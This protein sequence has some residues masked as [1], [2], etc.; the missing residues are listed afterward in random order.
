MTSDVLALPAPTRLIAVPGFARLFVSG[1]LSHMT[2]WG[3]LFLG[4]LVVTQLTDSPV[5]NQLVG[6]C[7]F[8]PMLLGGL[9]AGA[10]SD[11]VDRRRL[12]LA[13][14]A[15]SIPVAVAMA[16]VAQLGLVQV[17]MVLVFTLAIGFG[18]VVNMTGLRP[19]M[20]EVAGPTFAARALALDSAGV[21]SASMAGA[22]A[23][24]AL[25]DAVGTGAAFG[26]LAL[27]LCA[28][29]TL[30]R[31]VPSTVVPPVPAAAA[32]PGP[33]FDEQLQASLGLLRRSPRLASVLGVT[34][35]MNLFHFSFLPL[36]PVMA[37]Q[38]AAS[39]LLAGV[40]GSAAG[41]GQL[42]GGMVLATR[43]STSHGHAYVGGSAIAL[44]GLCL[45]ATAPVLGLACAALL[46]A[47]MGQA[48]FA[49]MQSLLAIE[50]ATAAERGA[51]LGLL[52][53]AIGALPLGMVGIGVVAEL[54]G[55]RATMLAS[56]L[57]GLALLAL[58]VRRLPHLLMRV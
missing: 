51:A 31:S 7:V 50:S 56:S 18:G 15:A 20:Y 42:V 19:L 13:T 35:V 52:S 54:L 14:Q 47:G 1:W 33:R 26:L 30:L 55:P 12:V 3:G 40:L 23:G 36:V 21:A 46:L 41:C 37:E 27:L 11:R 29:T 44:G 9:V 25:V 5:L 16:V 24:G 17:W 48:G 39:P 43:R 32:G 49:T 34:I 4:S 6:A 2:R 8:A 45:F 53:T 57:T 28:S 22:L 38:F 58:C 10:L